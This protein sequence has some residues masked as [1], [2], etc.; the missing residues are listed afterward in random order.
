MIKFHF[1][2]NNYEVENRVPLQSPVAKF[3]DTELKSKLVPPAIKLNNRV[4]DKR[5]N[6]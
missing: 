6:P 2:N 5:S 1:Y 4:L 3:I